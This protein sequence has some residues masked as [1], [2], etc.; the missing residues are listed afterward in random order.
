MNTKKANEEKIK[1]VDCQYW[2]NSCGY[3][4]SKYKKH[5]CKGFKDAREMDLEET[6]YN[7]R[8]IDVRGTDC[9]SQVI[10]LAAY[11]LE[12]V[13]EYKKMWEEF[14]HDLL[15]KDKKDYRVKELMRHIYHVNMPE[16]ERKKLSKS[17]KL[18]IN[19]LSEIDE[20]NE[21]GRR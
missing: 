16:E 7:L 14:Y 6:L 13:K 18:V 4:E 11:Y 10:H 19:C 20:K 1:C 9:N 12:Q 3:W 17:L 21:G 8:Q 5:T 15:Q 2:P